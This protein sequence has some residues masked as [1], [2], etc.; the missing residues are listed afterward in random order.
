M[1]KYL[2]SAGDL[3]KGMNS[4]FSRITIGKFLKWILTIL[5][6]SSAVLFLYEKF[7]TSTFFYDRI[8]RKVE[9]IKEV[10]DIGSEDIVITSL[11]NEKLINVLDNLDPPEGIAFSPY[12][13]T[14]MLIKI[15]GAAIIP[16]I[17]VLLTWK[18]SDR[19][20]SFLGAGFFLIVFGLIA[21][22]TPVIYSSW[23]NFGIIIIMEV[24]AIL[25]IGTQDTKT[26][27]SSE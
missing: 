5:I 10:K 4:I 13:S 16:F 25:A 15:L 1:S 22:I 21:I 7:F 17:I 6:I 19:I 2:E 24:L 9:I 8:D 18:D 23:V 3:L 27:T 20:D 14:D 26:N 11:A 12:V